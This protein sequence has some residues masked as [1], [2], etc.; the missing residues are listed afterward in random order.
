MCQSLT[1][2]IQ[3][4]RQSQA[5]RARFDLV[6]NSMIIADDYAGHSPASLFLNSQY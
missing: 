1:R 2:L 6:N 5:Q 4:M 3:S